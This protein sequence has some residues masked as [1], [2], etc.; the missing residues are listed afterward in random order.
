M[1]WK[2]KAR[3]E[4]LQE[5]DKNTAFF[6]NSVKARRHGNSIA[7]LV[8]ERG[9]HLSSFPEM[10]REAVQYFESLFTEHSQ[11]GSPEEVQVLSCIPALVTEDMNQQLMRD[12]SIEELEG[13]VFNMKKGK[14]PR[15]DGFPVEFYQEFWDIIKF[16]LLAVV[17]ES[18][19]N[20]QMLRALNATFLAL[21]PKQEGADRLSQFRPISLCN[22]IYKIISKLMVDRLN[23]GLAD[24]IS[25][26]QSGFVAGR[27]ILDGIV[28][29]TEVIHSMAKSKEKAMFIK[30][31][32]AKAY[33]R[34]RWSFLRRVLSAFGFAQECIQWVWSCFTS[35]CFLVLINGS[36]SKIFGASRELR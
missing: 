24:L 27:K 13:V 5:G 11:G 21:I 8:N 17:Q 16:D 12:I 35:V 7:G 6:F 23:Q 29:A 36:H 20:K 9:E 31:D 34:V 22:V 1:Y 28:I 25:E 3:I 2:Q 30:L 10:F 14:A 15:P 26:E 4:W 32:M 33:D 19:H 18:Q